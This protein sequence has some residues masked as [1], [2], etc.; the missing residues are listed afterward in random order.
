MSYT[1]IIWD[2][3]G[4][5]VDDVA[6]SV[7]CVN[8]MFRRFNMPLT[9]VD[10]YLTVIGPSL[11]EYYGRYFDMTQHTMPELLEL[12]QHYYKLRT[13]QLTLMNGAYAALKKFAESGK[14]QYIVSSFE[15]SALE[16]SVN[17]L[18]VRNFF[19]VISG[20]DDINCGPKSKRARQIVK[21]SQKAVLIGDSVC[22]YITASEAGCDCVLI[23]NGHQKESDLIQC[24][25][26]GGVYVAVFNDIDSAVKAILNM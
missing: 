18:G 8:D 19:T 24:K 22:D 15:Q 12:F 7:D 5:L 23:S 14:N 20:A 9:T 25:Q 11:E 21:K 10:E 16:N 26:N 6:V 3:N 1:E 4:T 17:I 2:W 13:N